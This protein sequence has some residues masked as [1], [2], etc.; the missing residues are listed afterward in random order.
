[1]GEIIFERVEE[2]HPHFQ[3]LQNPKISNLLP[4]VTTE[5]SLV[6]NVQFQ[7]NLNVPSVVENGSKINNYKHVIDVN[8]DSQ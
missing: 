4:E 2:Q 6:I 5:S 3:S 8:R 7:P 1:M